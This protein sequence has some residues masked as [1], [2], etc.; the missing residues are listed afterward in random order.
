MYK[1]F[2]DWY[3]LAEITPSG[4]ILQKRWEGVEAF[5]NSIK[6]DKVPLELVRVFLALKPKNEE[7]I[8]KFRQKFIDADPAFP[9]RDNDA[10]VRVLAASALADCLENKRF[11]NGFTVAQSLCCYSLFGQKKIDAISELIGIASEFLR[12]ES[13]EAR[14]V[15]E[16]AK[17]KIPVKLDQFFDE[18]KKHAP[19]NAFGAAWPHI[20]GLF[21]ALRSSLVSS[22]NVLSKN[23]ELLEA[24][25][26]VQRE[27][28][29]ILWW[30]YGEY[31]RDLEKK[32]LEIT[33][34]GVSLILAKELA[35]LTLRLPGP[36]SSRAFLDKGLSVASVDSKSETS[37][38]EAVNSTDRQWRENYVRDVEFGLVSEFC[39][40]HCALEKSIETDGK[41]DWVPAFQKSIALDPN[42]CLSALDVS[43]QF[44]LECLLIDSIAE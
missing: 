41:D 36:N 8:G 23:L 4:E 10:E 44:Y 13:V 12:Q 32:F 15:E 5:L 35:D 43:M 40:I 11:S 34:P 42:N 18:I 33:K 6:D 27:E 24:N 21:T 25:L 20:E 28:N 7:F 22:V 14:D 3:R 17:V 2:A 19:G 29:D 38:K 37:I 26:D 39:P 16:L 1:L 30:L 9:S 31:S